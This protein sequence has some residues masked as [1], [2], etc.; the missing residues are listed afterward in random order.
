MGPT[1]GMHVKV[2][3]PDVNP[4]HEWIIHEVADAIGGGKFYHLKSTGQLV[5]WLMLPSYVTFEVYDHSLPPTLEVD[6]PPMPAGASYHQDRKLI[7]RILEGTYCTKLV[8]PPAEYK[9]TKVAADSWAKQIKKEQDRNI[10][11][12]MTDLKLVC[13]T[14]ERP[15]STSVYAFAGTD[16]FGE[17]FKT[18]TAT[19][20]KMSSN[21]DYSSWVTFMGIYSCYRQVIE[22]LSVK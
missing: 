21:L 18:A 7:K 17:D 2:K 3:H 20:E 11:L 9:R 14:R 8:M 15:V 12:F 1:V 13:G 22:G 19:W 10:G 5:Q 4:D 16:H 6:T